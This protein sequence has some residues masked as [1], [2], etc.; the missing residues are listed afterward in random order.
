MHVIFQ[1]IFV[2]WRVVSNWYLGFVWLLF[3]RAKL[4][5]FVVVINAGWKLV[6][7]YKFGFS[8]S[9][10]ILFF[11]IAVVTV[12][13]VV[14]DATSIQTPPFKSTTTHQ[15]LI[16]LIRYYVFCWRTNIFLFNLSNIWLMALLLNIN[17]WKVNL[18]AYIQVLC[19]LMS[20]LITYIINLI[21]LYR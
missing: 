18:Q 21:F 14:V 3:S 8:V 17:L 11:A 7:G 16:K 9:K 13:P 5:V 12:I 10:T 15:I 19:S 1:L 6:W 2:Y 4:P 20:A